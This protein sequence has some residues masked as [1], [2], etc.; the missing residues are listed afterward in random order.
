MQSL[1]STFVDMDTYKKSKG[2]S[3][4]SASP[5]LKSLSKLEFYHTKDKNDHNNVI[6]A[7]RYMPLD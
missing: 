1:S 6:V 7:L 2:L 3:R 4:F 5:S